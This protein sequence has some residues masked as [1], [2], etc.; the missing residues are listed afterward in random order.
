MD[1]VPRGRF[2][3]PRLSVCAREPE[4]LWWRVRCVAAWLTYLRK[5]CRPWL[6]VSL[7]KRL[8]LSSFD[9]SYRTGLDNLSR[10]DRAVKGN[11]AHKADLCFSIQVSRSFTS[12]SQGVFGPY[13]TMGS[14]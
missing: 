8:V 14:C 4:P 6:P 11:Q 3:S 10:L 9:S 7:G 13:A 12:T 2:I 1:P 5:P